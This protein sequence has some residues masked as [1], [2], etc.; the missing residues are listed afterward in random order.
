MPSYPFTAELEFRHYIEGQPTP[1][2]YCTTVS[3][4]V[5][6]ADQLG[7]EF[8]ASD[9]D[10]L[11]LLAQEAEKVCRQELEA[12]SPEEDFVLEKSAIS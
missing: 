9:P 12:Y 6:A 8:I 5:E 4:T 7:A 3:F 11:L 1:G 2:V 10:G